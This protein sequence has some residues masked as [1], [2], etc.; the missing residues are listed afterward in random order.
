MN[1]NERERTIAKAMFAV[2]GL[3]RLAP[4]D[5]DGSRQRGWD[6]EAMVEGKA[7]VYREFCSDEVF[8]GLD[9]AEWDTAVV[10]SA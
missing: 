5:C 8:S 7:P 4:A 2:A 1:P 10:L 9:A 6:L 3:A